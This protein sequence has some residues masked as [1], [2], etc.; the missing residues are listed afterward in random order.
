MGKIST[1][2][3]TQ[4][5]SPAPSSCV[6]EISDRESIYKSSVSHRRFEPKS[7]NCG[8]HSI[9]KALAYSAIAFPKSATVAPIMIPI[10]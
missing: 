3:P 1:I 9:P 6:S 2:V 4:A 10:L 7:K 8:F 5:E